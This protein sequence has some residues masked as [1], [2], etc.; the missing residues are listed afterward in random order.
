MNQNSKIVFFQNLRSHHCLIYGIYAASWSPSRH[1][2]VM[3]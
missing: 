1:Y 3:D 2:I